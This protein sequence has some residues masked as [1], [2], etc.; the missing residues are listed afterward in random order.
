VFAFDLQDLHAALLER[1]AEMLVE[2]AAEHVDG[3]VTD[4]GPAQKRDPVVEIQDVRFDEEIVKSRHLASFVR[5]RR[6]RR[7]F[8]SQIRQARVSIAKSTTYKRNWGQCP[9]V[10]RCQDPRRLNGG[11]LLACRT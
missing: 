9:R 5:G 4:L 10:S 8:S 3:R 2:F 11:R 1:A 7:F 6:L